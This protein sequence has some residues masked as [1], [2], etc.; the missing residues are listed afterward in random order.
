MQKILRKVIQKYFFVT[1]KHKIWKAREAALS[2]V[3]TKMQAIARNLFNESNTNGTYY[4]CWLEES[5][6]DRDGDQIE[7]W[8]R[9]AESFLRSH[10]KAVREAI[11]LLKLS[12]K[13]D[14]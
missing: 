5:I 14:A 3:A 1:R 13:S 8:T 2:K 11:N 7:H 6:G 9:Q 4:Y 10:L 12:K